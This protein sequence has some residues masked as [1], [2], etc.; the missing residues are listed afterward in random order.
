M[1]TKQAHDIPEDLEEEFYQISADILQSFNKFRPPLNIFRLKEDVMRVMPYYRTGERLSKEQTEELERLVDEGVIF[2]SRADHAVYV[3]H[4][5]HQLDLVLMDRHLTETECADIFQIA[6]TR[7]TAE[8][9]DQPVKLVADKLV[10]DV[11][12]VTEYLWQDS[13]RSRA[14]SLRVHPKHSLANH[15]VNCLLVGLQ[16]F[17][18]T[19]SEDFT[20]SPKNRQSL[21]RTAVG[22]LLHDAGMSKIPAFILDKTQNITQEERQKILKHP[23][24]GI[25]MLAKLDLKFPEVEQSMLHHH[26][27]LNGTGYP[28]KLAGEA[29]PDTGLL[30]AVVDSY[31]A[32]VTERPY[33]PAMSPKVAA[34]SLTTDARYDSRFT[35]QLMSYL[36]NAGLI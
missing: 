4:I 12:V 31:C 9:L 2:V 10:A 5:S 33:A 26:E 20:E 14:L 30:C 11:L 6:L 28:Q 34:G 7:R 24:L 32:M 36:V 29:I 35:K 21:D 15:S 13:R 23:L 1:N 3:N 25:E 19:R 17:V 16:L 8:F 18:Q 27:R 22:L